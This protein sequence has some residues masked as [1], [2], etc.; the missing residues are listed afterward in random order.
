MSRIKPDDTFGWGVVFSDETLS[1]FEEADAESIR[2]IT[3]HFAYWTNIDTWYDG[4]SG[5]APRGTASPASR[6]A[7]CSRSSRTAAAT[8]AIEMHFEREIDGHPSRSSTADL[9]VA[10]DGINSLTR[11]DLR[12]TFPADPRLAQ[13]QVHLARHDQAARGV[14]VHLPRERTRPLPGPCLSVRRRP[15]HVHRR[16]P[17]GDLAPSA[18]PRGRHRRRDGRVHRPSSLPI[19]STDTPC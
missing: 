6:A 1:H 9:V 17:R 19:T 5:T 2:E 14:H 3:S 18:G 15:Q 7:S 13:M 8:S 10:G 11:Q 4:T 12:R 16:V